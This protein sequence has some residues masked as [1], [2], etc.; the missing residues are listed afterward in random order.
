MNIDFFTFSVWEIIIS[1]KYM[2]VSTELDYFCP[3]MFDNGKDKSYLKH[4]AD[5]VICRKNGT[6]LIVKILCV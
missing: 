6:S 5:R 1:T 3:I 2:F 4:S